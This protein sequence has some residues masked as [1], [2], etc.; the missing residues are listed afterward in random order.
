MTADDITTASILF[1]PTDPICSYYEIIEL[2][3]IAEACTIHLINAGAPVL[4]ES[5]TERAYLTALETQLR[6]GMTSVQARDEA[7]RQVPAAQ[8]STCPGSR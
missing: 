2:D 5:A 8:S 4:R 7:L 1:T 6:A 3:D